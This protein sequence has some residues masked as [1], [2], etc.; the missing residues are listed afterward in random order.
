M[1]KLWLGKI[2]A[3][4]T[5]CLV[6]SQENGSSSCQRC[7]L[8]SALK[9]T[10]LLIS[11]LNTPFEIKRISF[12]VSVRNRSFANKRDTLSDGV[13]ASRTGRPPVMGVTQVIRKAF[14]RM[15]EKRIGRHTMAQT[16]S[17][18]VQ[19]VSVIFFTQGFCCVETS[20]CG[21]LPR[22]KSICTEK[23]HGHRVLLRCWILF[24]NTFCVGWTTRD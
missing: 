8:S 1:S 18:C 15:H 23:K 17:S 10:V 5:E 22:E 11:A 4:P 2:D 3:Q 16:F 12:L 13:E 6:Q 7:I 24:T 14:F 9:G 19:T 20:V 21:H